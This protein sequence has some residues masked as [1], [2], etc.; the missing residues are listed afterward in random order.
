MFYIYLISTSDAKLLLYM[1]HYSLSRDTTKKIKI[2]AVSK[3]G[4][5]LF[6][7]QYL[8]AFIKSYHFHQYPVLPSSLLSD[9]SILILRL[10][11]LLPSS[12][13]NIYMHVCSMQYF[14]LKNKSSI[15]RQISIHQHISNQWLNAKTISNTWVSIPGL[16]GSLP[17]AISI[18]DI[19]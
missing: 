5:L 2:H 4:T 7:C 16:F 18:Q 14:N 3:K 9:I 10:F 17:L 1:L 13:T 15:S 12:S 6:L 8:N 11:F 19:C